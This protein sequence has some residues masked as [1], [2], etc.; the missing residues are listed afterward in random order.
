MKKTTTK[1]NAARNVEPFNRKR[2]GGQII[3]NANQICTGYLRRLR[4]F[5]IVEKQSPFKF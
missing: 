5:N 1:K 3:S 2:V 4:I